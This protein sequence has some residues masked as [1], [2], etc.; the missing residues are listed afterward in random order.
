MPA[1]GATEGGET[2][3]SRPSPALRY[4]DLAILA[5]ALPVFVLVGASMLGYVVAAAAWILQRGIQLAADRAAA[6]AL[7]SGVRRNALGLLAAS[8]LVRLWVVTLAIL[9]VGTLGSSR[10]GLAAAILSLVLVTVSLG[11]RALIQALHPVE[12]GR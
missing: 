12:R 8:T 11:S 1:R 3:A 5:V 7:A 10:A 4:A 2:S 6:R 9:L